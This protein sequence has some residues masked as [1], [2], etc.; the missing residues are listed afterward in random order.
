M[1]VPGTSRFWM[2]Y[3]GI[4]FLPASVRIG[5]GVLRRHP[6]SRINGYDYL[7]HIEFRD[8]PQNHNNPCCALRNAKAC[9]LDGYY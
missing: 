9:L 3:T 7:H 1:R 4:T 2:L 5:C 8:N 6:A